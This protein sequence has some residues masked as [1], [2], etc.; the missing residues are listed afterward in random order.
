MKRKRVWIYTRLR[1]DSDQRAAQKARLLQQAMEMDY[2]VVGNSTDEAD[3]YILY[4]STTTFD[5]Y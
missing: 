1:G 3:G 5:H 4:R 2:L